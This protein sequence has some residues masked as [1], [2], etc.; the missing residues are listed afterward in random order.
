M[1]D[2]ML[3]LFASDR[4]IE[5]LD[6]VD[7][8]GSQRKAA[9]ALGINR[10]S[11]ERA[12][13]NVKAAA[14]KKGYS[15]EHDMTHIVP[16][17][18][19]VKGVSGYYD[20]DGNLRGQW[21]KSAVDVETQ[22]KL[23]KEFIEELAESVRGKH[24]PTKGPDNLPKDL[25]SLYGLGDAHIG[26]YAWA[27]ECGDDFDSEIA[28][29]DIQAAIDYLI[30]AQPASEVGLLLNV[31]DFIHMDNRSN[32]TPAHGNLLDVDTRYARVIR[33]A[34]FTLKYC[35]DQLLKKHK[36]VIVINAQGNHDQDSAHWFSLCLDMYYE[37]EPRVE[38]NCSPDNFYYHEFGNV[39]IGAT[40]GDK[41]KQ[42]QLA[43]IMASH[44]PEEWGR[45]KHRYFFTGHIHH[46]QQIELRGCIAESLNTLAARD[47]F[48]S[49]RGY[50]SKREMQAI[51]YHKEYG[52]I[53]R[54]K[55]PIDAIRQ[56]T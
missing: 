38:I 37:R 16:E 50:L 54:T 49:S 51:T 18:F 34:A 5:I 14:A 15:P 23:A 52:E 20:K 17:G 29:R 46:K 21:V 48:H 8:Y 30:K 26:M 53:G 41:V 3:R 7:K 1:T 55:C 9:D 32:V 28:K 33:I 56:A 13:K 6:A 12:L 36:K 44:K 22:K 24:R 2:E 4:Q 31:G 27:D 11:V 43:S 35:I 47:S 19:G 40:H 39:L 45:T 42:E 10:R 25:L